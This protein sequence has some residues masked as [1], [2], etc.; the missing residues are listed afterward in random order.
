MIPEG[1]SA[2]TRS[3]GRSNDLEGSC[4]HSGKEVAS[5][6]GGHLSVPGTNPHREDGAWLPRTFW[7]FT[8]I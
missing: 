8:Q 6:V 4:H 3:L 1:T 5:E 7:T 2:T